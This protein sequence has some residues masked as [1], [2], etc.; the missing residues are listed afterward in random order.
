MATT[1]DY[2]ERYGISIQAYL[3]GYSYKITDSNGRTVS[4]KEDNRIEELYSSHVFSYQ[5]EECLVSFRTHKCT[6]V[7]LEML[8]GQAE[9]GTLRSLLAEYAAVSEDER[10]DSLPV[11]FIN[12]VLI[13]AIP[14]DD[15]VLKTILSSIR[16][17]CKPVPEM[18]PMLIELQKLECHNRVIASYRDSLLT[19]VVSEDER[20]LLCNSFEAP[21]F[22]TAMYFIFSALKQ[23]QIN[24]EV[25]T[26]YFRNSLTHEQEM[27]VYRYFSGLEIIF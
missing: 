5:Y 19:L 12:A 15:P 25:T 2:I 27:L 9:D 23:F 22:T 7:P 17:D 10:T 3:N 24:P 8:P 20:L 4:E 6:L 1:A 16:T 26:I 14:D 21:D 18:Y 13:Y 11:P